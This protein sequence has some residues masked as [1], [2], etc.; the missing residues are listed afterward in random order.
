METYRDLNDYEIMYM[1][2]E[3]DEAR[4]LLFDK[5]RPIIINIANK[6][7][8]EAKKLGLELDDL[9][10]EGYLGLYAAIR[11]YNPNENTLF[12]TYAVL[13]IRSKMLNC[14]KMHNSQKYQ[15]LNK[16]VSLSKPIFNDDELSLIDYVIDKNAVNP[17]EVI[18]ENELIHCISDFLYTL[19]INLACIFE[20][21]FNGF[22]N[23]DISGLL[24]LPYKT[25]TN[26]LFRIRKK[27]NQYYNFLH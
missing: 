6:Y 14:L 3:S 4:D 10:Q 12:Y 25:V 13:S 23:T 1:V 11:N 24:D 16:S 19:D 27:L 20:L 2:E 5:Y 15:S 8:L 7:R 17:D 21:N 26:H 18:Q 9:I 22:S